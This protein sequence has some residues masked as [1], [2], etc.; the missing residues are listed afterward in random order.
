VDPADDDI[1][2]LREAFPH[3][4]HPTISADSA[5]YSPYTL[6]EFWKAVAADFCGMTSFNVG[7]VSETRTIIMNIHTTNTT[8]INETGGKTA[9]AGTV[10]SFDAMSVHDI[11]KQIRLKKFYD[12]LRIS[13]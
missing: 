8:F 9:Q 11:E 6:V 3:C 2:K 7:Q 4:A 12:R 1:A 10:S 5:A 13:H